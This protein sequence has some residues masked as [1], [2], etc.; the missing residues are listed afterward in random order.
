M[1]EPSP[2]PPP[3]SAPSIMVISD[4]AANDACTSP[5]FDDTAPVR[6]SYGAEDSHKCIASPNRGTDA[7]PSPNRRDTRASPFARRSNAST[8]VSH[9]SLYDL[10]AVDVPASAVSPSPRSVGVVLSPE[11]AKKLKK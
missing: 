5:V 9:R 2:S 11:Q 4:I 10:F 1:A 7:L 3:L 6:L 8:A